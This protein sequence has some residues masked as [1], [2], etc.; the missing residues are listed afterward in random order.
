MCVLSRLSHI[1][2]SVTPWTVAYQPPL[3]MGFPKQEYWSG[4]PCP[5][6][7]DLPGPGSNLNL[8]CLLHWQAGSSPL[9]SRRVGRCWAEARSKGNYIQ[10]AVNVEPASKHT[11]LWGLHCAQE[12]LKSQQRRTPQCEQRNGICLCEGEGQW[13]LPTETVQQAKSL[14]VH[15]SL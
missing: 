7:G 12:T 10:P 13:K 3:P 9:R 2:L 15:L 8:L 1:W 6:L 4:L 14:R 11:G 5:P